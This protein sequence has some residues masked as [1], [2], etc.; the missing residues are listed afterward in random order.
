MRRNYKI[1]G[2]A[3][4]LYRIGSA[5]VNFVV[6]QALEPMSQPA[7]NELD[8]ENTQAYKNGIFGITSSGNMPQSVQE[9]VVSH[10][11]CKYEDLIKN[12]G[13]FVPKT[14]FEDGETGY[15]KNAVVYTQN[16]DNTITLYISQV[17][18]NKSIDLTDTNYWV[19]EATIP[20]IIDGSKL[21]L[22]NLNDTAKENIKN[23][24]NLDY[25][26]FSLL[27]TSL[28][29]IIPTNNKELN[30]DT[31][32][33]ATIVVSERINY[34]KTK[35]TPAPD[36]TIVDG[37]PSVDLNGCYLISMA[38]RNL[39]TS[40]YNGDCKYY[41]YIEGSDTLILPTV[42]KFYNE[43]FNK[44]FNIG[45]LSFFAR[46]DAP[47]G[48]LRCDGNQY[49]KSSF[50]NFWDDYLTQNKLPTCSYADYSNEISN[51]GNCGKF[52]VDLVNL[53]FKVPTIQGQVFISQALASGDIGKFNAESL[54]QHIHN[55]GIVDDGTNLFNYGSTQEDLP[56]N[57]IQTINS[58]N[59]T[60]T[61]Q[62]LTS[63]VKNS[64]T[65]QDN[66]I[67]QPNNIQYPI[68]VCVANVQVPVSEAQ[69]NGFISNL[70][71]KA[72][73]N[74]S[75]VD[76]N[77]FTGATL[78]AD[79]VDYVVESGSNAY[80][81]YK[82]FKSG[83]TIQGCNNINGGTLGASQNN[84]VVI[85]LPTPT[86]STNYI[87]NVNF[88]NYFKYYASI[89]YVVFEKTTT[90]FKIGQYNNANGTSGMIY[91]NYSIIEF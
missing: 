27:K 9:D 45:Q 41:T 49:T 68:F 86:Q 39:I 52:A 11:D 7:S 48:W 23:V 69:Y 81:F 34:L 57:A 63:K 18:N 25:S 35:L 46:T 22:N 40:T 44:N 62:G 84:H 3:R 4:S 33:S 24:I 60:P 47:S 79:T 70:T 5:C 64:T 58:E 36:F 32:T 82:K 67:N 26:D 85:T 15:D 51:N 16:N 71:L 37:E 20:G 14:T 72:D 13:I 83:K 12:A 89:G 88:D 66:A 17:D 10:L 80:G 42:Q 65:Y 76:E 61:Y 2:I 38:Q 21:T 54:P 74:G 43:L 91:Y 90:G 6:G 53:T 29:D 50:P 1:F 73:K 8:T 77:F 30:G 31:I 78:T 19:K 56:G 59:F 28:D 75:N 55:N 87:V